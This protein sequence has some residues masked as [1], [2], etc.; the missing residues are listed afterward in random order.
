MHRANAR[1]IR[2][3]NIE[4]DLDRLKEADWIVEAVVEKLDDQACALRQA[5]PASRSPMRS[6]APTPRPSPLKRADARAC[7]ADLARDFAITHFFNPPRYHAPAGDRGAARRRA[8]TAIARARRVRRPAPGQGR[9]ASARTRRASSPTASAPSGCRARRS[10]RWTTGLT[11]EEAD[12]VMGRPLG[13]PKTGIFGLLDLVGLDLQPHVDASL[14]AA[15]PEGRSLSGAAPRLAALR[16]DDRRGLHRPQRQGRLLSPGPRGRARSGWRRST[17]RPANTG[18]SRRPRLESVAAAKAGLQA[19]VEHPDKGGRYAWRVLVAACWPM[20]RWWR[21][22]SPTT[23]PPS[24]TPCA[25]ATTGNTGPSSSSTGW[26]PDIWPS[27]WRARS[28]PCRRCSPRRPR[29]AASIA[30]AKAKLE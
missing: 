18:R 30:S 21:R 22:R 15:L 6:S 24:M 29:P 1:L 17:S 19:L 3:G 16:Q 5:R 12:A 9:R 10:T 20:P 27:A 25:S 14:A 11:V 28:C 13:I 23:S 8:A 7:R 26:A 2:P 4:D